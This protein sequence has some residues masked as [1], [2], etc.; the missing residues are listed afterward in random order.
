MYFVLMQ[1]CW[2]ATIKDFVFLFRYPLYFHDCSFSI[3]V[4]WIKSF[5]LFCYHEIQFSCS[6]CFFSDC[7]G[8]GPPWIGRFLTHLILFNFAS[9]ARCSFRIHSFQLFPI[10]KIL[11]PNFLNDLV[12]VLL[13]IVP[14]PFSQQVFFS[15][16]W[17]VRAQFKLI[18]HK[19][20]N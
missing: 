7:E 9:L 1:L 6:G 3:V 14:S 11:E 2:N 4:E 16:F 20:L 12:T 8:D 17:D 5:T 15:C 18:R 10:I 13:W 19:L